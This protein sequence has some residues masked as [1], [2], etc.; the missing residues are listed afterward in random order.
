MYIV[1][2]ASVDIWQY[3]LGRQPCIK[4]SKQERQNVQFFPPLEAWYQLISGNSYYCQIV[5]LF[6]TLV[7]F[8]S[9]R[10]GCNSEPVFKTFKRT[11]SL[12]KKLGSIQSVFYKFVL[13]IQFVVD[14]AFLVVVCFSSWSSNIGL[15][16]IKALQPPQ[17]VFLMVTKEKMIKYNLITLSH[18]ALLLQKRVL[19][20]GG[21]FFPECTNIFIF[22]SFFQN[23]FRRK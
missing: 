5:Y 3:A 2:R 6:I 14:K 20:C 23:F 1:S 15:F 16:G 13:F 22:L 8:L 17:Q 18:S 19:Y 9:H 7:R 12:K 11:G 4:A 21:V 10:R